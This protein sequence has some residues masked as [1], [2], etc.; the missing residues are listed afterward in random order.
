MLTQTSSNFISK[1]L[2]QKNIPQKER[3][4]QAEHWF[5]IAVQMI[6]FMQKIKLIFF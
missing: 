4:L 5:D 1:G 2:H 6:C 3:L